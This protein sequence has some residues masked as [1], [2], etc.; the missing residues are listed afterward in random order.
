VLRNNGEYNLVTGDK[1]QVKASATGC[2][3]FASII[4]E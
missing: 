4:E 1:L 3:F 2:T